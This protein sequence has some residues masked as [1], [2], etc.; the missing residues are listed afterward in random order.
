MAKDVTHNPWKFDAADQY[1]GWGNRN[2][3][4][5]PVF[6]SK[7]F[8]DFILIESGATGGTYDV[9]DTNGGN[10]VTGLITL[11][12]NAQFQMSVGKYLEGVYI[13]AFGTDGQILVYHGQEA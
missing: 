10:H 4:T 5:A 2:E 6:N 8:V 13:E 1:E 9:R 12:A 11:G 7:P 3:T